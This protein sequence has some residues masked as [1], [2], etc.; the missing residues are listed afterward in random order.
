MADNKDELGMDLDKMEDFDFDFD[1][2]FGGDFFAE[3]PPPANKREAV[4]RS[5]KA[6]GKSFAEEFDPRDPEKIEKFIESAIPSSLS[7]E[8]NSLVDLK[9][10]VIK[11]LEKTGPEIKRNSNKL[12]KTINKYMPKGKISSGIDKLIGLTESEK[13][14]AAFGDQKSKEAMLEESISKMIEATMAK[15]DRDSAEARIKEEIAY[16]KDLNQLEISNHI[17]A[18]LDRL[19]NFEHTVT[20]NYYKKSLDLQYRLLDTVS[21]TLELNKLVADTNK[22]QLESI[23]RN[24]S[25]PDVVKV[26]SAEVVKMLALQNTA[27]SAMKSLFGEGSRMSRVKNRLVGLAKDKIANVTYGLQSANMGID[28]AE[29]MREQSQAMGQSNMGASMGGSMIGGAARDMLGDITGRYLEGNE[30][31]ANK[32][33]DIKEFFSD[34]RGWF[35]EKLDESYAKD[36]DPSFLERRKRDFLSTMAEAT[37]SSLRDGYISIEKADLDA[38]AVYTNRTNDSITKTIPRLLSEILYN[39]AGTNLTLQQYTGI[40]PSVDKLRLDSTTGKLISE[41]ASLNRVK[42]RFETEARSG[43]GAYNIR[44]ATGT[45]LEGGKM[46]LSEKE[47]AE[48]DRAVSEYIM[49]GGKVTADMFKDKKLLSKLNDKKLTKRVFRANEDF[50]TRGSRLDRAKSRTDF[51]N[52]IDGALTS[53]KSPD[54]LFSKMIREGNLDQLE[55]LGLI[56]LTEDGTPIVDNKRYKELISGAFYKESLKYADNNNYKN[57][58]DKKAEL[59]KLAKL[60]AKERVDNLKNK[61][62]DIKDNIV[63][64]TTQFKNDVKD[65]TIEEKIEEAL[66]KENLKNKASILSN[67]ASD[68]KTTTIESA[69]NKLDILQDEINK[70]ILTDEN[71]EKVKEAKAKIQEAKDIIDNSK[72]SKAVK[73]NV[74]KY[75]AKETIDKAKVFT[76]NIVDNLKNEISNNNPKDLVKSIITVDSAGTAVLER[77]ENE[78]NRKVPKEDMLEAKIEMLVEAIEANTNTTEESNEISKNE[79]KASKTTKFNDLNNDGLRDGS[80]REKMSDALRTGPKEVEKKKEEKEDKS[81]GIF[82]MILGGLFGGFTSLIGG[83]LGGLTS[84]FGG[85]FGGLT[86]LISGIGGKIIGPL[87][88][89]LAALVPGFLKGGFKLAGGLLK[90]GAKATTKFT[91]ATSK[92]RGF[93]RKMFGGI[94]K[95]IGGAALR[96]LPLIGLLAG[97]YLG[98]DMIKGGDMIGGLGTMVSSLLAQIPGIGT[99]LSLGVDSL[100]ALD[101]QKKTDDLD[102]EIELEKKKQE[103]EK[104]NE[105]T[106]KANEDNW[107]KQAAILQNKLDKYTAEQDSL[108]DKIKELD[109]TKTKTFSKDKLTERQKEKLAKLEEAKKKAEKMKSDMF[110]KSDKLKELQAKKDKFEEYANNSAISKVAQASFK[111]QADK[112]SAEIDSVKND[113]ESI[114]KILDSEEA[115][116]INLHKSNKELEKAKDD[117]QRAKENGWATEYE[118]LDAKFNKYISEQE[119]I[120]DEIDALTSSA[121]YSNSKNRQDL[122]KNKEKKLAENQKKL[123]EAKKIQEKLDKNSTSIKNAKAA[124]EKFEKMANDESLPEASRLQMR[125]AADKLGLE[126]STL[127]KENANIKKAINEEAEAAKGIIKTAHVDDRIKALEKAKANIT[128]LMEKTENPEVKMRYAENTIRMDAEIEKLKKEKEAGITHTEIQ[129]NI[130]VEDN[131]YVNKSQQEGAVKEAIETPIDNSNSDSSSGSSST[132]SPDEEEANRQRKVLEDRIAELEERKIRVNEEAKKRN[133]GKTGYG[134][135]ASQYSSGLGGKSFGNNYYLGGGGM[136]SYDSGDISLADEATIAKN[137]YKGGDV[138]K[139]I[140]E[141]SNRAGIDSTLM[142]VMAAKESGFRVDVK[143]PKSSALGLYQFIDGTWKGGI[144][145]KGNKYDGVVQQYGK[146]YGLDVSNASRL[147]PEHSTLMAAEYLKANLKH[148]KGVK[149][150]PNITDAYLTHFAGPGGA[151]KI[152]SANPDESAERVVGKKVVDANQSI[153]IGNGRVRTIREV[154]DVLAKSLAKTAGQFGIKINKEDVGG[155]GGVN[156]FSNK[157]NTPSQELAA[158]N[159]T[160]PETLNTTPRPNNEIANVPG[161][162]AGHTSNTSSMPNAPTA[163]KPEVKPEVKPEAKSEITTQD[164][165]QSMY[166]NGIDKIAKDEKDREKKLAEAQA[167]LDKRQ[168]SYTNPQQQVNN[169]DPFSNISDS[170]FKSLIL[171]TKSLAKANEDSNVKLDVI[172]KN[173]GETVAV[174]QKIHDKLDVLGKNNNQ[175]AKPTNQSSSLVTTSPPNAIS[176]KRGDS[177][178]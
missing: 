146:K 6:A 14:Y 98:Y 172:A 89:G 16:R 58:W 154:Y 18:N 92:T 144:D 83:L 148:I 35:K 59:E 41:K 52:Y 173:T 40:T 127:E 142:Q 38:S 116:Y 107:G 164:V 61:A 156:I 1:T 62:R 171:S 176:S 134:T 128:S 80:F 90:G 66:S 75:N 69:T 43:G 133:A 129:K 131:K 95:K 67:R 93:E 157:S 111:E 68:F 103:L 34:P 70:I 125:S 77:L 130:K 17:V 86:S 138:K 65:G 45:F 84:M 113:M 74:E 123:E 135:G 149:P 19:I 51:N 120:K 3:E 170:N 151:K 104:R 101:K 7:T 114:K 8:F 15:N 44:R 60:K 105:L 39:T 117:M 29:S 28:M 143:N 178:R 20:S 5:L 30:K 163:P 57:Q 152:L 79:H 33:A 21:Q 27:N 88:G 91:K 53:I 167:E 36:K 72:I 112:V 175:T 42:E 24:T 108:K 9:E 22:N 168:T 159:T 82:K 49:E 50:M 150:N 85:M 25:L 73:A 109:E 2:D 141:A 147:N 174:L 122:V 110:A 121:E 56:K 13:A 165:K 4:S 158:T 23:I 96:K 169:I 132:L 118:N 137:S 31:A 12:L 160:G 166:N 162:T 155:S 48:L 64:T 140:N 119:K 71:R 136:G 37:N 46:N 47:R 145:K 87:V 126:I 139:I 94:L 106:Q 10:S 54:Q 78:V 26:R 76:E 99:A 32:I 100:L 115:L 11:E 55:E 153:F 102:I 81:S 124:K 177:V 161:I 63:D 97:G